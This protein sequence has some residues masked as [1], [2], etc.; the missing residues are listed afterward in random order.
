MPA[1]ATTWTTLTRVMVR[2]ISPVRLVAE[3]VHKTDV[4]VYG[5]A[6]RGSDCYQPLFDGW[7]RGGFV[8]RCPGVSISFPD[9]V[10]L[11]PASARSSVLL[12]AV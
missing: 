4:A 8:N 2:V 5:S 12:P 10:R 11:A 6:E 3:G 7:A 1:I 9:M